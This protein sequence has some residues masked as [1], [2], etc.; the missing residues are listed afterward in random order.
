L[1]A[2]RE[3]ELIMKNHAGNQRVVLLIGSSMLTSGG[4]SNPSF[5]KL[6]IPDEL[7]VILL[8]TLQLST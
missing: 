3:F 2:L 8:A 5:S 1:L 4:A 6:L 7:A